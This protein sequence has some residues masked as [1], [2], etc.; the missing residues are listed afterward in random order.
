MLKW[1]RGGGGRE[2]VI[3]KKKKKAHGT[4]SFTEKVFA[5]LTVCGR[6]FQTWEAELDKVR[7]PNCF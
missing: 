1:G 6:A 3:N 4:K 5:S 7:K 2:K